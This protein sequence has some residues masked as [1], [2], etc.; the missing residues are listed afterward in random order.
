[1]PGRPTNEPT[2]YFAYGKQTSKDVE[3]TTFYF[4]KH[5]DGSGFEVDQNITSEHEG[6]D[7]QEV[8]LRYKTMVKADGQGVANAR[9]EVFGRLLA[10]TLGADT[11]SVVAS[12]AAAP[13]AIVNHLITPVASTPYITIEQYFSDEVERATNAGL[14]Q[15]QIEGEAGNPF[16]LTS[17]FVG[18]G[19]VYQRDVASVLTPARETFRP[20]FFPGGSYQL[21][22]NGTYSAKL[23]KFRVDIQRN[24]DDAIQ[25]TGI[26]REDVIP[27]NF[28]V[29]VDGTIKYE[30]RTLYQKIQY[31]GGSQVNVDLAT[32]SFRMTVRT[33]ASYLVDLGIPFLQYTDTKVNKLDPDGKT[34]YL[35]FTAQS[36][37]N[38]TTTIYA[39]IHTDEVAAY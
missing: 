22:A 6:G 39:N 13:S 31:N 1:M 15:L 18:G 36:L 9:P 24:V 8:G 38:A 26:A 37:R 2:N 4:L 20:F 10:W 12:A 3:A 27:L 33:A 29:S 14:T 19:T 23:T 35:D 7:G 28:E 17:N 11:P 16:K 32:G 5:L 21:D 30:D 34:V 25:T